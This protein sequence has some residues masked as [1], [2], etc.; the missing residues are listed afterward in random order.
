MKRILP[1]LIAGLV[2]AAALF[3]LRPEP[4]VPVVTAART[5]PVG[6]K[7]AEGD[8]TLAQYPKSLVPEG[9]FY[10]FPDVSGTGLTGREFALQLL[11]TE[12][13]AV[14]PGRAFGECGTGHIRCSYATSME[15]LKESMIRIERFVKGL[16]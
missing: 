9:A 13:V 12:K 6:H 14:V 7:I 2:F 8:L 1:L 15:N 4:T 10:V 3:L 16:K 11:N 5:L